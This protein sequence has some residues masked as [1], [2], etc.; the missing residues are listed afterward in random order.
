MALRFLYTS[1][2]VSVFGS[3]ATRTDTLPLLLINPKTRMKMSGKIK[4]NMIADGLLKTALRLPMVI[5]IIA[6]SWLYDCGIN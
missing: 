1:F 4:L 2:A 5:A 3:N 6:C